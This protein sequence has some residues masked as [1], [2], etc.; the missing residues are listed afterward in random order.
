MGWEIPVYPL[1][2]RPVGNSRLSPPEPSRGKFP[3]IPSGTVPWEIPV[4]PSG[5]VS[6][7]IPVYPSG[8]ILW[9]IPVYP[10]RNHLVGNSRLSPPEPS[11]GKFPSIPSGTISWEIPVYPL[12]N[13]LVGNSRLSPPE[14]SRGKFPSI[15]SSPLSIRSITPTVR[16]IHA[17]K[18][19]VAPASAPL[20]LDFLIAAHLSASRSLPQNSTSAFNCN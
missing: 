1:R 20:K 14:P 8:T 6:W 16:R 9:E 17:L 10:L 7:E 4:Y 11:R 15:P 19:P 18:T 5:T 2:N 3:S 13:R 12:R